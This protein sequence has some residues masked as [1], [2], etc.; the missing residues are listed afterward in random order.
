MAM[1]CVDFHSVFPIVPD[2][3]IVRLELRLRLTREQYQSANDP[4]RLV[5]Q[6]IENFRNSMADAVAHEIDRRGWAAK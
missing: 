3:D 4:A 1:E 6:M 2:Q 5:E